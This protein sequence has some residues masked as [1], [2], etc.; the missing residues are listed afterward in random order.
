MKH[1]GSF[2]SQ[3][4]GCG[5]LVENAS[6]FDANNFGVEDERLFDVV[7]DGKDGYA[8]VGG[9]LL[10]PGKQEISERAVDTGEGFVQ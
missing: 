6:V 8:A 1:A 4:L 3:D 7:R 9:V 2:V 10:H 5:A